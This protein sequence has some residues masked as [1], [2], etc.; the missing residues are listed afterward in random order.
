MVI[1]K[2]IFFCLPYQLNLF[3][4]HCKLFYINTRN[5]PTTVIFLYIFHIFF[6]FGVAAENVLVETCTDILNKGEEPS[7]PSKYGA[8]N[9]LT[10]KVLSDVITPL[11]F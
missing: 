3:R 8:R 9:T 10:F 6:F 4:I 1:R 5:D 7:M 2:I 11:E